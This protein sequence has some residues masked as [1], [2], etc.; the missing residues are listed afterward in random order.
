MNAT[1]KVLYALEYI[2]LNVKVT[3]SPSKTRIG[4]S[5]KVIDE[6]KNT[7]MIENSEGRVL[8]IP[9]QSTVFMFK[10]GNEKFEVDGNKIVYRPED[11]T[12]KILEG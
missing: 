11:R 1:K 5:G 3:K 2:G 7:F 6:T 12:K 9:K 4:I 8:K 10:K